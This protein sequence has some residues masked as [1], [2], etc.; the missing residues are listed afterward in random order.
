MGDEDCRL[1]ARADTLLAS[2]KPRLMGA[3]S[4]SSSSGLRLLTRLVSVVAALFV[5]SVTGRASATVNL[6]V[7]MCGE[8][9]E[10]VAAPPIFRGKIDGGSLRATPCHAP[11]GFAVGQ[12]AP[13]PPERTV[14]YERPERVLG[15]G[16]LLLT[17]ADSSRL[18]MASASQALERPGFVGTLFRPPRA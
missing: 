1:A 17:Q 15:F 9:N 8:H 3:R 14:V 18:S 6:A 12:N 7:P 11:D 13:A 5:L 4:S 10:S 16:V 2:L